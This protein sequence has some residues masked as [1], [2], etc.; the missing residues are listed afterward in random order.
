MSR[1]LYEGKGFG[2]VRGLDPRKYCLED[3]TILHLGIQG[4]IANKQGRQDKRGNMM[5]QSR[6]FQK[7]NISPAKASRNFSGAYQVSAFLQCTS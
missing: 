7:Q 1:D 5:G 3:L 6:G 2:V 4:Y